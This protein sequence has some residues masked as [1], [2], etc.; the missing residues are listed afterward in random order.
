VLEGIVVYFQKLLVL[1]GL[2]AVA[3]CEGVHAQQHYNKYI[4]LSQ[5]GILNT[6]HD[7]NRCG[8]ET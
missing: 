3:G 4:R 7:M 8:C 1:Q 6:F 2:F 5:A